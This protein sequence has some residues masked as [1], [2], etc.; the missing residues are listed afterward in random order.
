VTALMAYAMFDERL[1]AV[2]IAGMVVIVVAVALA[3]P[4]ARPD[5]A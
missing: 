1:D 2:A 3:R 4:A 5:A